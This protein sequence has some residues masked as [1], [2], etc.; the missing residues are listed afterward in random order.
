MAN[1][2]QVYQGDVGVVL[3]LDTLLDIS[4]G[5]IFKIKVLR[6]D[7]VRKVWTGSLFGTT[8]VAYVLQAGD[9]PIPGEYKIQAFVTMPGFTGHGNTVALNVLPL[10]A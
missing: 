9:L 8:T 3:K 6:P 1:E 10:F 4:T 5:S 7:G 2:V